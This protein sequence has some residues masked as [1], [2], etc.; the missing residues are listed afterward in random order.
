MDSL[1][2]SGLDRIFTGRIAVLIPQ[3]NY[4]FLAKVSEG[5]VTVKGD[6]DST[7]IEIAAV[8]RAK[9][10]CF[11][12]GIAE[13]VILTDNSSASKQAGVKEAEWLEPGR[14]NYASLFLE[15]IMKRA[16]YLRQSSRKVSSRA[17]PNKLQA[18]LFQMFNADKLEF[19]LS[20]SLL[21]IKIQMEMAAPT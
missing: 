3:L 6:P 21:W 9:E 12:K 15:R 20:D 4:G 13:Y 19:Q 11:D 5:A 2:S 18:E 8:R 17:A 1:T 16:R 10:I 14:V 7:Q